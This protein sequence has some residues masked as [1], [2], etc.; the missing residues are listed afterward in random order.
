[1]GKNAAELAKMNNHPSV[2]HILE[3]RIR[4]K[5]LKP[6]PV[7]YLETLFCPDGVYP[8]KCKPVPDFGMIYIINMIRL[9]TNI[10]LYL[11]RLFSS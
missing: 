5:H 3:L 7:H 2:T 6:P 1:M 10:L 4:S 9:C 11:H 8:P